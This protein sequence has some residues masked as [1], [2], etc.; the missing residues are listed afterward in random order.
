MHTADVAATVKALSAKNWP[1]WPERSDILRRQQ[2]LVVSS[3]YLG[4][5]IKITDTLFTVS[6]ISWLNTEIK[7]E[8]R[9]NGY[10]IIS[11]NKNVLQSW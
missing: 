9:E 7:K 8:I 10:L 11:L 3:R 1:W 5:I 6:Q 4:K 2:K